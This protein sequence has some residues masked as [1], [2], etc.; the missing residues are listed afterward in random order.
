MTNNINLESISF[1]FLLPKLHSIAR[2]I[3]EEFSSGDTGRFRDDD[4]VSRTESGVSGSTHSRTDSTHKSDKDK[5]K[6]DKEKEDKDEESIKVF[7][8]NCSFRRKIC[9]VIQIPRTCNLEYFLTVA[10]RAFHITRDPNVR[11]FIKR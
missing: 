1:L 3:S 2:S 8:G 10:L 5:D 9:R 6:K 4:Y 11:F 7:D